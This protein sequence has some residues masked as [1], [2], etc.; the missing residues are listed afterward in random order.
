MNGEGINTNWSNSRESNMS[1]NSKNK[2]VIGRLEFFTR[3]HLNNINNKIKLLKEDNL[4]ILE[5]FLNKMD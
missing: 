1:S 3:E 5:S 2:A 4:D